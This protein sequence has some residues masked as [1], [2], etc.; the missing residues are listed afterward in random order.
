M[1]AN[2]NNTKRNRE[3][4]SI[5]KFLQPVS[6]HRFTSSQSRKQILSERLD[7]ELLT[8]QEEVPNEAEIVLADQ[9]KEIN[10]LKRKM[11][12]KDNTIKALTEALQKAY[13]LIGQKEI[14]FQEL[15]SDK[16]EVNQN[17]PLYYSRF[18]ELNE[19]N[20]DELRSIS[21]GRKNDS[22]FV[23]KCVLSLYKNDLTVLS[24][25]TAVQK[26]LEKNPITPQKKVTIVGLF[27][28]R[29]TI[30]K[31]SQVDRIKRNSTLNKLIKDAIENI[32]KKKERIFDS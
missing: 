29:L 27:E 3:N 31:I 24:K 20:L 7:S 8:E 12:E 16:L 18:K 15:I 4:G 28:E 1:K 2:R 30:E 17:N 13:V 26:T 6:Q 22:E 9:K 10:S 19:E 14:A 5:I 11:N 21:F 32:S 25:K 23:R